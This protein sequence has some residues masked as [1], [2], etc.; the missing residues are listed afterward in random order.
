MEV[1]AT[2]TWEG[3]CPNCRAHNHGHRSANPLQE[4]D[5]P[6]EDV[7]EVSCERCGHVY[8]V[9]V[10]DTDVDADLRRQ[11][12]R[13]GVAVED[14]TEPETYTVVYSPDPEGGDG[15]D[16]EALLDAIEADASAGE[17]EA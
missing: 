10:T 12:E 3:R 1:G 11:L 2:G 9:E 4:T 7:A 6:A 17:G 13:A 15:D 14:V 8:E 16:V 5:R